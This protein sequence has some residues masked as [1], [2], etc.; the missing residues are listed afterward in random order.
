MREVARPV[1]MDPDRVERVDFVLRA[2]RV[3]GVRPEPVRVDGE[4]AGVVAVTAP[5]AAIPHVSQYPSSTLPAQPGRVQVA[6]V[7]VYPWNSAKA[8]QF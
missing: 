5:G 3:D 1:R 2:E 4:A 7:L 6:M 8:G